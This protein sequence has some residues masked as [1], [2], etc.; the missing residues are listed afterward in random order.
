[1]RMESSDSRH[2]LLPP[3]PPEPPEDAHEQAHVE[4]DVERERVSERTGG[5]QSPDGSLR[6]AEEEAKPATGEEV[7]LSIRDT[8]RVML[9]IIQLKSIIIYLILLFI[10]KVFLL[11]FYN[12]LQILSFIKNV[13]NFLLSSYQ[14]Q[15][16]IFFWSIKYLLKNAIIN[17]NKI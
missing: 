10:L 15:F 11:D 16:F 8:Y 6:G 13:F 7:D 4:M 1:M 5:L 2:P 3:E 12:F 9:E 17:I 14:F